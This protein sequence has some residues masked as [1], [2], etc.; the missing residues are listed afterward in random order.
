MD[1]VTKISV[2]ENVVEKV[3]DKPAERLKIAAEYFNLASLLGM[4]NPKTCILAYQR[5]I[6]LDPFNGRYR[7]F[8][9]QF[10]HEMGLVKEAIKEFQS[11]LELWPDWPELRL[12]YAETLLD[13][14][15]FV[16]AQTELDKLIKELPEN[17][18]VNYAQIELLL[19]NN[20]DN[21]FEKVLDRLSKITV[22]ADD[23]GVFCEKCIKLLVDCQDEAL[24]AKVLTMAEEKIQPVNAKSEA[25]QLLKQI[26]VLFEKASQLDFKGMDSSSDLS[27]FL[28]SYLCAQNNSLNGSDIE[29][30]LEFVKKWQAKLKTKH[31]TDVEI[32]H[33]Y[34]HVL[35]QW[36]AKAYGKDDLLLAKT[37]W[38]ESSRFSRANP[39]IIQNLALVNTR[40][41]N[42]QAS[43][44]YWQSLTQAWSAYC[45]VMPESDGFITKMMTKHQAFIEAA[46]KKINQVQDLN[47][48][49]ELGSEWAR[50]LVSFIF[51]SQL[52]FNNAYFI[53]GLSREDFL[54]DAQKKKVVEESYQSMLAWEKMVAN[55]NNLTEVSE[56]SM[57]RTE[58]IKSARNL[59]KAGGVERF[60]HY[61][62]E[63]E[64]FDRHRE[65]ILQHY[66][67][68]LFGVMFKLS[69]EGNLSNK[70]FRER[71]IEFSKIMLSFPHNLFKPSVE[72]VVAEIKDVPDMREVV[73]N[74][75]IGYW[76]NNAQKNLE[77][78]QPQKAMEFLKS[79]LEVAPESVSARFLM[80]R[81]HAELK[82]FGDA[83]L[84]LEDTKQYCREEEETFETIV[85]FAENMKMAALNTE[86]DAVN[87]FL[88][89]D[90]AEKAVEATQ[91]VI[92]RYGEHPYALFVL[93]QAYL[94]DMRIKDA[95]KVIKRAQKLK[96]DDENLAKHIDSL[97][98]MLEKDFGVQIILSRA[99]QKMN[100]EKWQAALD[101]LDKG[102]ADAQ[103]RRGV[104]WPPEIYFYA[105]IC[106]LRLENWQ[107]A[108]TEANLAKKH[109]ENN[110]DLLK[111]IDN[112]L[113][114][115]ELG[116]IA[117]EMKSIN[118]ALGNEDWYQANRIADNILKKRPDMPVILFYKALSLFRMGE[119]HLDEV[120]TVLL[121][122]FS[123]SCAKPPEIVEQMNQLSEAT[124]R[125]RRNKNISYINNMLGR[126][127][128]SQAKREAED[129][130]RF[131]KCAEYYYFYSLSAFQILMQD[132]QAG[133]LDINEIQSLLEDCRDSLGNAERL[134]RSSSDPNLKEAIRNLKQKLG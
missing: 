103:G 41:G 29:G 54:T 4:D 88:A 69:R 96:T 84:L 98:E 26:N 49:M 109:V 68:L 37:L 61:D 7:M 64:T 57:W 58:R 13:D 44:A 75:A 16:P 14:G 90:Q 32:D 12:L 36:A 100:E 74:H 119:K 105:S 79:A 93:A 47:D 27:K 19:R 123:L 72:K 15:Q 126:G 130:L 83:Y 113:E 70:I 55:W 94:I 101:C 89:K 121:K 51:L 30:S 131:D 56:L 10:K 118:E 110:K 95:T 86:L 43:Q 40:L 112:L 53:D 42:E 129:L 134:A 33:A 20:T 11:A 25:L 67:Q 60:D 52:H 21:N 2:L 122:F 35:D 23:A 65:Y 77:N 99:G 3:W 80:A 115:I 108:K 111:Q 46:R 85:Q 1:T 104:T 24:R 17:R 38:E 106:H 66:I 107:N 48:L 34:V 50:E 116:P 120:D 71:F 62:E 102:R 133:R 78:K 59:I 125:V 63:K 82:A 8:F 124:T 76:L 28:F 91:K 45:E 22:Q 97:L 132:A 9:A 18:R 87:D 31:K 117:N 114:Q 128:F 92:D 81:C 39:A 73:L 5:A 6:K 127:N